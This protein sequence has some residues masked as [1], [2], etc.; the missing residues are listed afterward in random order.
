MGDTNWHL[1]HAQPLLCSPNVLGN[2]GL[3]LHFLDSNVSR[4]PV[5]V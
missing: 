4:V 3:E 1:L 2:D 5:M